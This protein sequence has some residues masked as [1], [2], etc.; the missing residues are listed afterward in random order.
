MSIVNITLACSYSML[1]LLD[2]V[3]SLP[4]PISLCFVG[5]NL[6]NSSQYLKLIT[7][8]TRQLTPDIVQI[9]PTWETS[10]SAAVSKT[11]MTLASV[12]ALPIGHTANMSL[13]STKY[14]SVIS[15]RAAFRSRSPIT[16]SLLARCLYSGREKVHLYPVSPRAQA[17]CSR[18]RLSRKP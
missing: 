11:L 8:L 18:Y 10:A 14:R 2:F 9:I 13:I 12:V 3:G 16:W 6:L 7:G 1:K 4:A 15:R 17:L 5:L